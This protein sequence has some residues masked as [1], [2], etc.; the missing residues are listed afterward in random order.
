MDDPTPGIKARRKALGWDRREL[1][2]RA[3]LDPQVVQLLEMGQW[4]EAEAIGRVEEVLRRAETGEE[5]VIL[6]QLEVEG[7]A[8]VFEPQ[9][10]RK[11]RIPEA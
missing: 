8:M 3:G 1:A 2:R 6:V 10:P 7:D 5:A 4:S 11:G 9:G